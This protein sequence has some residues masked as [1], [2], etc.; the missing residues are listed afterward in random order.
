MICFDCVAKIRDFLIYSSLLRFP[1]YV[2]ILII[3]KG[4]VCGNNTQYSKSLFL[5]G[6]KTY[7]RPIKWT[8]QRVIHAPS[9]MMLGVN[10][11]IGKNPIPTSARDKVKKKYI[12]KKLTHRMRIVFYLYIP[13]WPYL[14]ADVRLGFFPIHPV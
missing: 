2:S 12:N 1:Y 8:T 10:G 11:C 14:L 6:I 5:Y 4:I 9:P 7:P 13:F 3:N